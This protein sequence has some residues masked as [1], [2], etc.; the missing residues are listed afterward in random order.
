M[1]HLDAAMR[2]VRLFRSKQT[3]SSSGQ[4]AD[5][6]N[7]S[8][9]STESR[10]RS[11]KRKYTSMPPEESTP[12]RF[13]AG[14]PAFN[15]AQSARERICGRIAKVKR[16]IQKNP[17][18]YSTTPPIEPI[19]SSPLSPPVSPFVYSVPSTPVSPFFQDPSTPSTSI[20]RDAI[21]VSA[22]FPTVTTNSDTTPNTS[23]NNLITT[24]STSAFQALQVEKKIDQMDDMD[25]QIMGLLL[26]KVPEEAIESRILLST[27]VHAPA[28]PT[29]SSSVLRDLDNEELRDDDITKEELREL[30]L[31]EREVCPESV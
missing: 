12:K 2:I 3:S 17:N 14:P 24:T 8:H 9:L 13:K 15:K 27:S 19:L 20:V 11:L 31:S 18:L 26:A 25:Y 6:T 10:Q 21:I 7:T 28:A 1:E 4:G 30:I 22:D 23:T 16:I 29:L 5:R